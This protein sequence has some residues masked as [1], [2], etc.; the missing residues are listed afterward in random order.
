MTNY[1]PKTKLTIYN[2][3]KEMSLSLTRIEYE[4]D[5]MKDIAFE[6]ADSTEVSKKHFNKMAKIYHKQNMAE[7]KAE[8]SDLEDLYEAVTRKT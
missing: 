7:I 3:L 8:N 5:L 6:V 4:R 1:N 2:A